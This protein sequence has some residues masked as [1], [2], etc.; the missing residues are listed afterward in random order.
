MAGGELNTHRDNGGVGSVG[1]SKRG[2]SAVVK[3][4]VRQCRQRLA[5]F[6]ARHRLIGLVR[7]SRDSFVLPP[8]VVRKA[9]WR[10]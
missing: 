7:S 4:P 8:A 9:T 6:P 3:W 5:W 1:G 10:D 2:D